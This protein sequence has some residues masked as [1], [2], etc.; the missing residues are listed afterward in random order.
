MDIVVGG[1]RFGVKAAEYLVSK[2][3]EFIV[4]DPDENCDAAKKFK[5]RFIKAKAK[6]LRRFVE[7]LK[8]EWIFPTA[9]IHVAAEAL[10]DNFKPWK[11]KVNEI[12]AGLP[13]KVIVSIGKGSIAVSYNRDDT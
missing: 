5:E 9:P 1:G 10:S 8:P 11:E 7:E 2:K 3:R 6:D 4:L 13:L 12:L